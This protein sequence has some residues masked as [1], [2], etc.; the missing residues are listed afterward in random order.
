MT[1]AHG[2]ILIILAA[3]VIAVQVFAIVRTI[4]GLL[5]RSE[6]LYTEQYHEF[7]AKKV[8][9]ADLTLKLVLR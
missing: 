5:M 3:I 7:I 4:H 1:G 8:R 9:V 6:R 2:D